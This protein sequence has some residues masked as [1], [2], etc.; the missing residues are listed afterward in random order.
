MKL[1]RLK[2]PLGAAL[3]P[4]AGG[5]GTK[6]MLGVSLD[7][8]APDPTNPPPNFGADWCPL[9]LPPD[10]ADF[11]SAAEARVIV[12]GSSFPKVILPNMLVGAAVPVAIA[13]GSADGVDAESFIAKLSDEAFAPD[14]SGFTSTEPGSGVASIEIGP[15]MSDT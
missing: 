15:S 12:P 6:L 2:N 13:L 10:V 3:L 1:L 5:G 8:A 11:R 4:V 14:S 9:E 7:F